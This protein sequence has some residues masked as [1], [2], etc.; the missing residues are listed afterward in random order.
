M[1]MVRPK[2][3][4]RKGVGLPES[5][6]K[7]CA[8]SNDVLERKAAINGRQ[9]VNVPDTEYL[10]PIRLYWTPIETMRGPGSLRVEKLSS[11]A[12]PVRSSNDSIQTAPSASRPPV[13]G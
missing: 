4:R 3:A 1:P 2:A 6:R 7:T 11:F 12:D 10:R 5:G 9:S 8:G 13:G